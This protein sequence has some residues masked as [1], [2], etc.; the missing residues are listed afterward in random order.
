[1]QTKKAVKPAKMKRKDYE[2]ELAK[3]HHELV[4]LHFVDE[5]Y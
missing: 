4:K 5:K 3:L 2:R 1:M